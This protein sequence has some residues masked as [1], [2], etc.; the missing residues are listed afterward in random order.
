LNPLENCNLG[1]KSPCTVPIITKGLA[2][3]DGQPL[4]LSRTNQDS[5]HPSRGLSVTLILLLYGV[6]EC[7]PVV[8]S[9]KGLAALGI[10]DDARY[11]G[12]GL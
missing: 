9:H 6:I 3:F 4:T 2:P 5:Q 8:R 7:G 1:F 10:L 12:Q 11:P